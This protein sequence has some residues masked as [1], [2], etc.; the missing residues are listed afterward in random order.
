MLLREESDQ[1]GDVL[2]AEE[3]PLV[4]RLEPGQA[5]VRR[6]TGRTGPI[7]P[8]LPQGP[9]REGR[10]IGEERFFIEVKTG[11]FAKLTQNQR[12]LFPTLNDWGLIARGAN[13]EAA[14][15]TPGMSYIIPGFIVWI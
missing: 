9:S 2:A 1:L 4:G 8:F 13:A 6:G 11:Q 5:P 7:G 14:G 12:M 10:L 3:Q 15:L